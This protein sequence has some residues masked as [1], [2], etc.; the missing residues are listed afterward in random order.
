MLDNSLNVR[1]MNVH[2]GG[3][4]PRVWD[5]R[6]GEGGWTTEGNEEGIGGKG[7]NTSK[8]SGDDTW[9]GLTNHDN[10]KTEKTIVEHCLNQA[11][12]KA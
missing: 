10:F 12:R 3:V 6:Y 11:R 7:I 9:V 2:P 5:I 1:R 8:M 4:Q